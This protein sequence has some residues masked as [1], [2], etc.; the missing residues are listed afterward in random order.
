MRNASHCSEKTKAFSSSNTLCHVMIC[1][2]ITSCHTHGLSDSQPVLIND[3]GVFDNMATPLNSD[4][5][6]I[7]KCTRRL[8][9]ARGRALVVSTIL[10]RCS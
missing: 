5:F 2:W 1:G 6:C 10:T 8:V 3:H 7:A 9:G 4:A